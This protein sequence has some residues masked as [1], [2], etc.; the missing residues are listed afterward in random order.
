[1]FV[2]AGLGP[3]FKGKISIYIEL[4]TQEMLAGPGVKGIIGMHRLNICLVVV[5]SLSCSGV[6]TPLLWCENTIIGYLYEIPMPRVAGLLHLFLPQPNASQLNG[7]LFIRGSLAPPFGDP[8]M[9]LINALCCLTTKCNN[10]RRIKLQR[11]RI[12]PHSN[13]NR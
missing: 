7:F 1:M 12:L 6:K 2:V 3:V 5:L 11:L 13:A 4:T 8:E 10:Y 9:T